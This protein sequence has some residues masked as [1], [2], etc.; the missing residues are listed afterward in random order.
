MNGHPLATV[1]W[2]LLALVA[3]PTIALAVISLL[4]AFRARGFAE[5]GPW[6]ADRVPEEMRAADYAAQ[7]SL[8]ELFEGERRLMSELDRRLGR[9]EAP[10]LDRYRIG[11]RRHPGDRNLS[12]LLEPDEP[13]AGALLLHGLTDSP[14]LMRSLGERLHR[15]GI[16]VLGL[17]LPGHGT[18]P[19][20]LLSTRWRDWV[21][22]TEYGIERLRERLAGRPLWIAGFSAGATLA[23]HNALETACRG[24][25]QSASGLILLAP[26]VELP[27]AVR[28]ALWH[29]TLAWLPHF[30]KF[31]WQGVKPE[32]DPCKY[33]SFPKRAGA[34]IYRLTRRLGSL[35]ASLDPADKR[36]L[37]PI[38]A[39]QSLADDTVVVSGIASLLR[40]LDRA[41]DE[42]V[43]FDLNHSPEL[44]GLVAADERHDF[45]G[46]ALGEDAL[47]PFRVTLVSNRE[48]GGDAVEE[49]SWP[50]GCPS[51]GMAAG[52][53][54]RRLA[55][56][57]PAGVFSLS[58]LALPVAAD[59]PLYGTDSALGA[60]VPRGERG[61]LAQPLADL[62]RLRWNPFFDY[63]ARRVLEI[64]PAS[65]PR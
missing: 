14:Y 19:G 18:A 58:H 32:Y 26:A 15:H 10:P 6:H 50:A 7:P 43:I 1:A 44:A 9:G 46:T 29:R 52:R 2:G 60:A 33:G 17:R 65:P 28:F 36:E 41:D 59:D 55:A 45:P 61:V 62:L 37:P 23:L 49:L 56:R 22:A 34:E 12:F 53:Q 54:R 3:A 27:W 4:R 13:A 64:L 63:L 40:R 21:A 11:G 35:A 16:S 8:E 48:T 24:G 39:F 47:P 25:S 31:R 42:L 38:L 51:A 30:S 57:W 20:G 5:L